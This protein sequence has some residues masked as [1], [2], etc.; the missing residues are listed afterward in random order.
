MNLLSVENLSKSY[1]ERKLFEQISFGLEKGQ[2]TA[3]VARNGTGKSTLLNIIAGLEQPD[4][5]TVTLRKGCF[6]KGTIDCGSIIIEE[7]AVISDSTKT[8]GEKLILDKLRT[9]KTYCELEKGSRV[10]AEA[11]K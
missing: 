9:D 11:S 2:K 7:G 1:G 6:V 3:L 10:P 4:E 8:L 5:G